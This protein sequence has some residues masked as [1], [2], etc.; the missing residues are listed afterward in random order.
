MRANYAALFAVIGTTFGSADGT[1]FN[2]PDLQGRAP[3]GLG[4]NGDVNALGDSD[5]EAVVANRP[6]KHPHNQTYT[7]ASGETNVS[8]YVHAAS[9]FNSDMYSA[10]GGGLTTKKYMRSGVRTSYPHFIT[11]NFI[12]KT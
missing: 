11:L 4:T 12:I 5:G 7:S 8:L 3:V 2:V 9:E 1:H 10:S 6:P